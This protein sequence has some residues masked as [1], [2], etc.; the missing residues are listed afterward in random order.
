MP[1]KNSLFEIL[2]RHMPANEEVTRAGLE[3]ALENGSDLATI[4]ANFSAVFEKALAS[5]YEVYLEAEE[6]LGNK[7]LLDYLSTSPKSPFRE[8]NGFFLSLTQSR[9]PRA[10]KAFEGVIR[11]LFKKC[12]YPFTEQAVINGKP[13][14]LLPSKAHYVEKAMD[15]IVFTAKRTLRERWRQIVTEGTKAYG[16]FLAT[17]DES[18]SVTQLKEMSANKIY[19]VVP[20]D[21]K[22]RIPNYVTA[23]N[24]ITFEDFFEDYLDPAV[25]RWKKQGV[26]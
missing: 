3:R 18:L 6:R 15:C 16:F 19:V 14:F 17:Q 1:K 9:R 20:I 24:V 11:T 25:A 12:E 10:G 8:L 2:A 13:D 22:K 7:V 26:I 4:K 5:A 23:N 21:V